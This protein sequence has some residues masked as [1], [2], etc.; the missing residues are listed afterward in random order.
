LIVAKAISDI[1]SRLTATLALVPKG[2]DT[3]SVRNVSPVFHAGFIIQF[4]LILLSRW[5]IAEVADVVDVTALVR[6]RKAP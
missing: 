4:A 5:I 2:T 3:L 1:F 6:H